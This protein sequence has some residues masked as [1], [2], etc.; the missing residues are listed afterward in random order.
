[1]R[2]VTYNV[3]GIRAAIGKGL[4]EWL[5]TTNPDVFCIQET[6]AQP[7]QIPLEQFEKMGYHTYVH[8]A[9]KRGYSG[10]ALFSKV[11]PRR[12]EYG[13]DG[14][15]PD[16]EG[17]VLRADFQDCSVM[18]VY[19]PSG[20]SGPARQHFKMEWLS[21]FKDYAKQLMQEHPNL[22]LSGDVNICHKPIDIHDPVRNAKSSGFL[23]EER[24]WLSSFLDMGFVDAFRKV[25]PEPH[26][27]TW[28]SYRV[29]ARQRNLGWK[30]DYHL[31]TKSLAENIE[32]VVIL[33]QAKHSDHCPVMIELR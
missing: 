22:V 16:P 1:M 20:S 18:S 27:Y 19:V 21:M 8:S 17:R 11:L 2:I 9:E 7:E 30:I 5:K 33:P 4:M 23:P 26:H 6:K 32:R 28:W 3:N 14:S 10:V 13:T 29:N 24:N 12:V 31:V 15:F 25:N